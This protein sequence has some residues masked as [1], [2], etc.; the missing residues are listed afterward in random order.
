MVAPNPPSPTRDRP[1]WNVVL[2]AL[3]EARGVT[4]D[5]WAAWL[6]YSRATIQR[7]ERGDAVPTAEAETAIVRVC[8]ERG[9]FRVYASGPLAGLQIT[10]DLLR[11]LLTDARLETPASGG[12]RH[13]TSA[14]ALSGSYHHPP[15]SPAPGP[16]LHLPQPLSSFVGRT[17]ELAEVRRLLAASRLLT[18]TGAGG[19]GK[20]RLAIAAVQGLP[21]GLVEEAW[22]VELASLT[23]PALVERAVAAACG[24]QEQPGKLLTESLRSA[25]RERSVLLLLDNCEHL[26]PA[27][28]ALV[29]ALLDSCPNMRVLATSRAPL[30]VP[31]E[32][33]WRVPA[34]EVGDWGSPTTPPDAAMPD[35]VHLFLERARAAQPGFAL[36]E[37]AMPVVGQICRRLDGIPLAIELAAAR[38]KVLAVE[39][40][41]ARLDDRF[42]LLTGGPRGGVL[43]RHQT[44]RAALDWSY[45]L[46]APEEQALLRRLAVFAGGCG[47]EAAEVVCAGEP[48]EADQLLDLLG[49]LVDQSLL[50][51]DVQGDEARYRLLE[52]VRQ[53][54]AER[55]AASGE[56]EELRRRHALWHRDWVVG[57]E[58]ELRGPRQP[59]IFDRLE[60]EHDNIRA[61]LAWCRSHPGMAAAGLHL[62][63]AIRLFWIYRGHATEGRR[64]IAHL[65]ELGQDAP[66]TVRAQVLDGAAA[67]AHSQGDL[68]SARSYQ[69]EGLAIWHELHDP[70]GLAIALN[71]LGLIARS[72]GD[73]PRALAL[74]EESLGYMRQA[75]Q[76]W[77]VATVLN[78]LGATAIELGDFDRA[79]RYHTESLAVKQ[80]LGDQAGIAVSLHNLAEIARMEGEHAR[81]AELLEE[82]LALWRVLGSRP[83]I[84]H[85]LHSLGMMS[86]RL[87]QPEQAARHFHEGIALFREVDDQ[88]G[89][90]MCL[91][92]MGMVL[93]ATGEPARAARLLGAAEALRETL[94]APVL[95]TDRAEYRR[96]VEAAQAGLA[97]HVFRSAWAAG[98]L[99]S[100]DQAIAEAQQ[101][102]PY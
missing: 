45:D 2:R 5:G 7:W 20:T 1:R 51:A 32:L 102:A 67:L 59:A 88:T 3:R 34:M 87:G 99:L 40:I 72:E 92:G 37:R 42:R 17:T 27:C 83:R 86:V 30:G 16:L 33:A 28:A 97:D 74:L 11:S 29:P 70:R 85:A 18:L 66:A 47:L 63:A 100:P 76:E 10:A 4:Q 96:A 61:A 84:A 65:L 6:G 41:A 31:G 98:R 12:Q 57:L 52:T 77:G 73:F 15:L 22:M 75:G 46:L 25:L 49:S 35:A 95:P 23:D 68:A 89:I 58:P 44:L 56:E 48:V 8:E 9:L 90:A 43:P 64:W 19:I 62:T 79:R 91:E 26:T 94:G 55:L 71:I 38:V 93:S 80:R 50:V 14:A 60:R 24:V 69:E 39:Q 82:T 21:S 36:S 13:E 101:P 81:A 54:A 53:Y 78:N